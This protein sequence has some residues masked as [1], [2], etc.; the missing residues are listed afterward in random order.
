MKAPFVAVAAS[1][2]RCCCRW[3]SVADVA[4]EDVAADD[5][6]AGDDVADDVT[7]SQAAGALAFGLRL[8]DILGRK[9]E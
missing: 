1:M 9:G 5:V 6:V 8:S 2:E 4:A 7:P 3:V